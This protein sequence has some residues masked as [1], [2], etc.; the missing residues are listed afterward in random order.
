MFARLSASLLV[1]SLTQW[2]GIQ[3]NTVSAADLCRQLRISRRT[4]LYGVSLKTMPRTRRTPASDIAR[5]RRGGHRDPAGS[6]ADSFLPGSSIPPRRRPLPPT[7]SAAEPA[8][9]PRRRAP[10]VPK[11][12]APAAEAPTGEAP[13]PAP[14]RRRTAASAE[15]APP[16]Q[17]KTPAPET[18][19]DPAP[20]GPPRGG[21][22]DVSLQPA[23]GHERRRRQEVT[24][25]EVAES[26]DTE[27][28]VDRRLRK[29]RL[30][31]HADA[32]PG[33]TDRPGSRP[34]PEA[35]AR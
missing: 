27:A 20:P 13:K 11:P 10:R 16:P 32:G 3:Y 9:T 6:S 1:Q 24:T 30:L 12:D 25:P 34:Q 2:R 33:A 29:R 21:C 31:P 7:T 18:P 26:V 5:H 22:P 8:K 17:P 14:R 15:A 23:A 35:A 19:A 28:P 4:I